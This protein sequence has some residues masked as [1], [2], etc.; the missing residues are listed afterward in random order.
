MILVL[1]VLNVRFILEEHKTHLYLPYYFLLQASSQLP[2]HSIGHWH[3]LSMQGQQK[4]R[5][6]GGLRQVTQTRRNR[7]QSFC[8]LYYLVLIGTER[9][10]ELHQSAFKS[11]LIKTQLLSY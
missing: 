7:T 6:Q 4:L 2:N 1:Q 8:A 9:F 10:T 3:T 11:N 5:L